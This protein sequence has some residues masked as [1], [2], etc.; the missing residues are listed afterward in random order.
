MIVKRNRIW[1]DILPSSYASAL[2]ASRDIAGKW[3]CFGTRDELHLY[4]DLLNALVE[5]GK[6]RSA[7]LSAKDPTADPF[8]YKPCVLCVFTSSS[9][10]ERARV[11]DTLRHIGL[12]PREWKSD[13]ETE[14]DWGDGGTL[15]LEHQIAERRRELG[16]PVADSSKPKNRGRIFLSH[17]SEDA[18]CAQRVCT[19]LELHGIRCWIAPRDI[20]PGALYDVAIRAG[21]AESAAVVVFVSRNSNASEHVGRE[22]HIADER[23]KPII[24][25]RLEAVGYG[26][27][28]EYIIAR[29]HWL[30]L[31]EPHWASGLRLLRETL[32]K[33]P[34]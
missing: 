29:R 9:M 12:N 18:A 25:V 10:E 22:L 5:E 31:F 14:K 17:A 21:L 23:G 20:P 3:L 16:I 28:M 7:K 15:A 19:E 30:D 11:A 1:I 2:T 13:A 27:A 4:I 8:P 24:P 6:L 26:E 34:A 33:V 32:H